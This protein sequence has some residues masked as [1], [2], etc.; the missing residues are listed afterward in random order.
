MTATSENAMDLKR[1][2]DVMILIKTNYP[3][4]AERYQAFPKGG[5]ATKEMAFA[6]DHTLKHVV[7]SAGA[8]AAELEKFDHS[9]RFDPEPLRTIAVKQTINALNLAN[10]LGITAEELGESIRKELARHA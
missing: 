6:A 9:G 3:F 2:H 8:L 4:N 10:A 7:K 5:N 1:L